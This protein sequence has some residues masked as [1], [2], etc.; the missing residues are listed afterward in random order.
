M[1]FSWTRIRAIL[2]KELR[3]YRRNRFVLVFTMT[4]L[5]LIFIAAPTIAAAH[6]PGRR[7]QLQARCPRSASRCCTC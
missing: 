5:P 4:L 7:V 1:S 3:D 6:R 2:V